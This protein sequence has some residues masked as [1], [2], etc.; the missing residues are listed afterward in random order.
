MFA[1]VFNKP[2]VFYAFLHIRKKN[3][4]LDTFSLYA[5]NL[6]LKVQLLYQTPPIGGIQS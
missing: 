1:F 6:T 4:L 2:S 5:K 3:K